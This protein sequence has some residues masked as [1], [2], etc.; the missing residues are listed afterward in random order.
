MQK[1]D[2][3]L[4]ITQ[5]ISEYIEHDILSHS[6]FIKVLSICENVAAKKRLIVYL[7]I[8]PD[9][10]T[11][12]I[13]LGLGLAEFSENM[14]NNALPSYGQRIGSNYLVLIEFID[15]IPIT[16]YLRFACYKNKS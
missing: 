8:G 11:E 5:R 9:K 16:K 14:D 2:R 3:L 13:R 6:H 12:F 7:I 15:V 1:K 4:L 10:N